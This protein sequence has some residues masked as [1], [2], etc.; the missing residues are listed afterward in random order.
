MMQNEKQ[1]PVFNRHYDLRGNTLWRQGRH[2]FRM[3]TMIMGDY[4][5]GPGLRPLITLMI[6]QY[7]GKPIFRLRIWFNNQYALKARLKK[8][9]SKVRG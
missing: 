6:L 2:W 3:K 7:V 8:L 9:L 5:G 1:K 4:S